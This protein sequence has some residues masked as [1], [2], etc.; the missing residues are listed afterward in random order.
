MTGRGIEHLLDAG[1][2]QGIA[3]KN[4]PTFGFIEYGVD[5]AG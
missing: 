1:Q 2:N 3:G 4:Y 5:R